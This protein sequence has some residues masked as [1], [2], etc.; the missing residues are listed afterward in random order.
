MDAV[1]DEPGRTGDA[2]VEKVGGEAV[3]AGTGGEERVGE[4]GEEG[5]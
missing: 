4:G 2:E 5:G 3:G 1:A